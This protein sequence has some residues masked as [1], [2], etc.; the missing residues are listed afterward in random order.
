MVPQERRARPRGV[1]LRRGGCLRHID[2]AGAADGAAVRAEINRQLPLVNDAPSNNYINKLGRSIAQQGGAPAA[3]PV[4][5]RERDQVNAFAVPGGH[6]YLNRGLI[7]R[8]ATCRSW[9]ACWRTRSR[10]WSIATASTRWSGQGANLALTVA[11]VLLGRAPT[12]I[13]RRRRSASA[14]AVLRAAQPGGGERGG[15]VGGGVCWCAG[16]DPKG[17]PTF[18]NVL[19][20]EQQRAE[21]RGAVVL[22]APADAGPVANTQRMIAQVPAAQLRGLRQ[23]GA[24]QTSSRMRNR[25]PPGLNR[26]QRSRA[27]GR[28]TA[29]SRPRGA[30]ARAR[31]TGRGDPFPAGPFAYVPRMDEQMAA[32]LPVALTIAGS[33]SGGGAGIQADLKTFHAFGVFGTSASRRSRCRTRSASRPCTR[34]RWTSCGPDRGGRE[35][36]QPAACKSGMLATRELVAVV[37][38]APRARAARTTCSTRSW[39]RRAATGCSTRTRRTPSCRGSCR[40]RAG[41]A[42]PGRGRHPAGFDVRDVAAHARA[43]RALVD[44]GP[45]PRW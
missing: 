29:A 11:Y 14:A 24:T 6:I 33:D 31:R 1:R 4:L 15:R 26:R 38:E 3:V 36:L 41:H 35:D 40:W 28:S 43:A 32:D 9:R 19:L 34:S 10:T 27:V 18:F 7:E 5:R 42:E 23:D 16:I 44:A 37:A 13:W 12:G 22:D 8:R 45:A 20:S 2:A 39:S 17:L 25:L 21:F 30:A